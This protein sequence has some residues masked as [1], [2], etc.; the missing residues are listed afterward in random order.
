MSPGGGGR[1]QAAAA[2]S[3]SP[4]EHAGDA[5]ARLLPPRANALWVAARADL[6][7]TAWSSALSS[8]RGTA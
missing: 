3:A 2:A 1:E 8:T 4:A 6:R 5:A 7:R